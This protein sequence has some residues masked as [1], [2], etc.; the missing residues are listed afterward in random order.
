MRTQVV[1]PDEYRP[2]ALR[3]YSLQES[4]LADGKTV[5][6]PLTRGQFALVDALDFNVV[7]AYK[8]FALKAPTKWYAVRSKM[9]NCKRFTVY[10]AR[11]IMN[12][13]AECEADHKDGDG[14][15]NRRKN[16]RNCLH[17]QNSRNLKVSR[18]NNK[19]GLKGVHWC[20]TSRRFIARIRCNYKIICLGYFQEAKKAALAYDE[21]AKKLFGEFSRL[22]FQ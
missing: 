5:K 11:E 10:M 17:V 8:W 9:V 3:G 6:V 1:P 22:N 21:A 15:N 20:N 2:K 19:T 4:L 14:L 7:S 12:T 13:S 18:R 16:L